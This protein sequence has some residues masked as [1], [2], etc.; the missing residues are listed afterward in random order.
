MIEYWTC[1]FGAVY[2]AGCRGGSWPQVKPGSAWPAQ[3]IVSL[4][5][6]GTVMRVLVWDGPRRSHVAQVPDPRAGP[7]EVIVRTG[8]AGICGSES[9]ATSDV[10]PTGR[11]PW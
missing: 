10:K 9:R 3:F 1:R 5:G 6:S 11:R 8:A 4:Q 7:D 2:G